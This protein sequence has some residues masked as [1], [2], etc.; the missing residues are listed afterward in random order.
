MTFFFG[1][2]ALKSY[3]SQI[4]RLFSPHNLKGIGLELGTQHFR[5]AHVY[6][7]V[8]LKELTKEARVKRIVSI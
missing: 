2:S 6:S 1:N 5:E 3:L 4:F 7:F 8:L